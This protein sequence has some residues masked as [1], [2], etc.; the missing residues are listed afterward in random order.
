MPELFDFADIS[1]CKSQVNVSLL[2]LFDTL[3]ER[4]SVMLIGQIEIFGCRHSESG[5]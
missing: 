2:R 4:M 3:T 5:K 1:Q